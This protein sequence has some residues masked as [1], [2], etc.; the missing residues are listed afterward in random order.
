[1]LDAI[2]FDLDGTLLPM[3]ND[4]F[5]KVYFGYLAK[6]AGEW[7]YTDKEKL[8]AGIWSGVKSMVKNN[9]ERA[10]VDAFWDTF[11]AV[12][13]RPCAPDA[14]K[15]DAFYEAGFHNARSVTAEAP[16]A[17][18]AV[19]LA[20]KKA[21]KVILA[22]NPIFPHVATKSRLSWIGLTP[23]DFDL[24]TDYSN[25]STCK[26]NPKYY[27]DI[28]GK[29]GLDATKCLMIGNDVQEDSE[30]AGSLG[31]STYLITDYLINREEKSLSCPHGSYADMVEYIR[32]LPN[33]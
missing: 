11:S 23:D 10:N 33:E 16:L 8:I 20:R 14:E 7:G 2:L 27:S 12:M 13:G 31:M 24:V 1:M 6:A 28:I 29:F 15:F 9:G 26:P 18:T 5:T 30:A 21:K 3:D 4:H 17:K 32:L 22:T 25:W 19:E